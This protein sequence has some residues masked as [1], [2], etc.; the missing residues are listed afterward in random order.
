MDKDAL[1]KAVSEKTLPNEEVLAELS[2]RKNQH[3]A[4]DPSDPLFDPIREILED[5]TVVADSAVAA[6][7][8]AVNVL[9]DVYLA[10]GRL[11]MQAK[12]AEEEQIASSAQESQENQEQVRSMFLPWSDRLKMTNEVKLPAATALGG[13]ARSNLEP[14]NHR[15][16]KKVS[17]FTKVYIIVGLP[18]YTDI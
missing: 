8:P 9:R 14:G 13:D 4:S 5:A 16:G 15:A 11:K 10:I 12:K 17:S 6:N 18:L 7:Q 1:I 2:A 3:A